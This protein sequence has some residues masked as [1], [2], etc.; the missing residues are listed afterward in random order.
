VK[1]NPDRPPLDG[2][3]IELTWR[4]KSSARIVECP[5]STGFPPEQLC[6]N[7]GST[8]R[9]LSSETRHGNVRLRQPLPDSG[10]LPIRT[11][12][13]IPGADDNTSYSP[14]LRSRRRFVHELHCN[15]LATRQ[16]NPGPRIVGVVR[17]YS[18][19]RTFGGPNAFQSQRFVQSSAFARS[20][21]STLRKP[22]H[23]MLAT[24]Y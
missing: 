21:A 9:T 8:A 23:C 19:S 6:A 18:E 24:D 10:S 4:T 7:C 14:L 11:S 5:I 12:R 13:E 22:K 16:V 17:A 1:D 3:A 15:G 2:K 20:D